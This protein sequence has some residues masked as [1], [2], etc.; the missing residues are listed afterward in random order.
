M[1]YVD[2]EGAIN[3]EAVTFFVLELCLATKALEATNAYSAV[4]AD[5]TTEI[6]ILIY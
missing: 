2:T 1:T 5:E 4:G 6:H 3:L